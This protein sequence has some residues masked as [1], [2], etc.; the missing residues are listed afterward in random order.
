M[1]Q[2][3]P[4]LTTMLTEVVL[5]LPSANTPVSGLD[6]DDRWAA[7]FAIEPDLEALDAARGRSVERDPIED[8]VGP[9]PLLGGGL[10]DAR[11][12]SGRSPDQG[13]RDGAERCCAS[14]VSDTPPAGHGV[15]RRGGNGTNALVVRW[16]SA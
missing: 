4:F 7:T 14:H 9:R 12:L 1:R 8:H 15:T 5:P 3:W 11:R 10:N 2:R 16:Y 6:A 13:D